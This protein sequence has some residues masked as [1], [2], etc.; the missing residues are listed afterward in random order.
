MTLNEKVK[1]VLEVYPQTT[2]CDYLLYEA[3]IKKYYPKYYM[4]NSQGDFYITF[5]NRRK[6][7]KEGS[8]VRWRAQLQNEFK[9][10]IPTDEKV[11]KKRRLH[12]KKWLD[13]LGYTK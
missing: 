4:K 6:V 12:S 7:P 13:D 5:K 1:K 2:N 3:V 10:C 8:V 11:L 9:E